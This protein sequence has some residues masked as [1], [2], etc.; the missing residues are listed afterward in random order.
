[1][2]EVVAAHND[3]RWI[4]VEELDNYEFCPADEKIL[5]RLRSL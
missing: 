2:I 5:K 1:M 3:I 4:A